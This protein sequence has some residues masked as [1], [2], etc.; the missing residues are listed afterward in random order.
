VVEERERE[1][2]REKE[3]KKE[4]KVNSP[5]TLAYRKGR[6]RAEKGQKGKNN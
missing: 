4:S 5:L 1:R 2:Q 6:E 3:A